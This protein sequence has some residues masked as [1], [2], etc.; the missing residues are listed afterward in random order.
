MTTVTPVKRTVTELTVDECLR[1]L[2]H[3]YVGRIATVRDGLPLVQPVNYVLHEGCVVIRLDYGRLLDEIHGSQ[4]AFEVD[5]IDP[6]YH[7][8][9]SVVVQGR[10]EEVWHPAELEVLRELPLRPWAPGDRDHYVRILP[11]SITGRRIG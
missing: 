9:W 1:L 8:G 6:L 4:V 2:E 10:A 5:D 7:S 11:R 3:Q